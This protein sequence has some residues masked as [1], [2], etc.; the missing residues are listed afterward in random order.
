MTCMVF[1]EFNTSAEHSDGG[2]AG[3]PAAWYI[4]K[5]WQVLVFGMVVMTHIN[6]STV[7]ILVTWREHSRLLDIRA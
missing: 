3:G 4:N 7:D 2:H 1:S 5:D 6:L